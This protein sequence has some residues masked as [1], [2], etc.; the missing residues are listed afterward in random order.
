MLLFFVIVKFKKI[1]TLSL[2]FLCQYR[3]I[4]FYQILSMKFPQLCYQFKD[5]LAGSVAEFEVAK[6]QEKP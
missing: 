1:Y 4:P 2:F 6:N 5:L 3:V